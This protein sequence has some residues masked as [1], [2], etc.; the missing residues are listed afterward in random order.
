MNVK[1]LTDTIQV[2]HQDEK[3]IDENNK[4]GETDGRI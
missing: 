2:L 3:V 4:E 1:D